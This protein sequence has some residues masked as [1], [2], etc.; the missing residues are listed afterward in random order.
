MLL[1]TL[2]DTKQALTTEHYAAQTSGGLKL[3]S[4]LVDATL[5]LLYNDETK[6]QSGY[7]IVWRHTAGS[8]ELSEPEHFPLC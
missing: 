2:E 1:N 8:G 7:K 6:A 5:F 4:L 3:S